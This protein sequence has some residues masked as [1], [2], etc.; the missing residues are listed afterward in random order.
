MSQKVRSRII[1][2]NTLYSNLQR[3][4]R[5]KN[6]IASTPDEQWAMGSPL[7]DVCKSTA[8]STLV[9]QEISRALYKGHGLCVID[10]HH[11]DERACIA[12]ASRPTALQAPAALYRAYRSTRKRPS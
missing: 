4:P 8:S 3:N 11:V 10:P 2:L 5:Q 1:R 6:V 9:H 7:T 12:R